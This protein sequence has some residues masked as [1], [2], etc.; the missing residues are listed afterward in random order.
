MN[1]RLR[2]QAAGREL[3][4]K[5]GAKLVTW[6]VMP[7]QRA[8]E[9]LRRIRHDAAMVE[10]TPRRRNRLTPNADLWG[11]KVAIVKPNKHHAPTALM[12]RKSKFPGPRN[13]DAR[14]APCYRILPDGTRQLW[15]L[16]T[17]GR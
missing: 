1:R 7:R 5:L 10:A 12:L 14:R 17:G 15:Q 2:R 9:A 8:Q 16:P 6:G 13:D 3:A 4:A 11:D